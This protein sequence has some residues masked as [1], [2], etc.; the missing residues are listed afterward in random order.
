ML[1]QHCRCR[2]FQ[3]QNALSIVLLDLRHLPF[4][5]LETQ[6]GL[7]GATE[8]WQIVPRLGLSLPKIN[9]T[10][11]SPATEEALLAS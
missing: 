7:L 9:P 2:S 4:H 3:R 10:F 1:V 6:T 5:N 11:G 8:S